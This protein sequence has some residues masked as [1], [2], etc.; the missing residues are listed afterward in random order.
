MKKFTMIECMIVV[1]IIGLL[2]AILF[3]SI[4]AY[5]MH[6][7]ASKA[8]IPWSQVE[9]YAK[10]NEIY[11]G[12]AFYKLMKNRG[13]STTVDTSIKPVLAEN[14]FE[15]KVNTIEMTTIQVFEMVDTPNEINIRN[16]STGQV[17]T[18]QRK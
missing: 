4:M 3:P 18:Y 14:P 2:V 8:G 15:K 16:K 10:D 11:I 9:K 12:D 17:F 13:E 1:A 5:N 7:K 6:K